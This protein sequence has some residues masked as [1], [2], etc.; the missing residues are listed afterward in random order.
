MDIQL[1]VYV[2][3]KGNRY[4]VIGVAKHTETMEDM[5]VYK[6]LDD[7]AKIW[8]RPLAMFQEKVVIDDVDQPRFKFVGDNQ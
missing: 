7:E 6:S 3:Y 2:H 5:V 4:Q 8:V 1:G